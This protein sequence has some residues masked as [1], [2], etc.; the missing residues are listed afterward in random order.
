MNQTVEEIPKGIAIPNT[1]VKVLNEAEAQHGPI[2]RQ[3]EAL[4]L[5]QNRSY[6]PKR[7]VLGWPAVTSEKEMLASQLYDPR[8]CSC[9]RAPTGSGSH[10]CRLESKVFFTFNCVV[11]DVA[12]VTIEDRTLFGSAVQLCA[13][14]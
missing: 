1:L 11:L 10:T 13:A 12:Q 8:F 2:K 14:T 7:K 4:S 5:L 3:Q 9:Q 6:W